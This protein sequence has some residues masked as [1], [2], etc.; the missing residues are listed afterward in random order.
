MNYM[1]TKF[2]VQRVYLQLNMALPLA[3]LLIVVVWK[4]EESLADAAHG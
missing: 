1:T 4:R 3:F 2:K